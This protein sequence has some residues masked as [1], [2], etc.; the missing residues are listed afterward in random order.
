MHSP[1]FMPIVYLCILLSAFFLK[2]AGIFGPEDYKVLARI[3][4]NLTLPAAVIRA[5]S[6]FQMEWSL[7]LFVLLGLMM[8]ILPI[9]LALLLFPESSALDRGQAVLCSAGYCIG[10]FAFPFID[11]SIGA[12]GMV[13]ACLFDTGNSLMLT[14]VNYAVA[15]SVAEGKR[16]GFTD[17]MR[18]LFSSVPFCVY[19]AMLLMSILH[20][21]LP[22]ILVS[23]ITPL[24]N[25][26]GPIAML[27]LG[28]TLDFSCPKAEYRQVAGI[29]L[30]R[31]GLA[32]AFSLAVFF[33]LP[34]RTCYKSALILCSFCPV[35][36]M[37]TPFTEKLRGNIQRTGLASSISVLM[38]I[39]IIV[40][41]FS[42]LPLS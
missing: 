23:A 26:N 10:N 19:L 4:V 7:L 3:I 13:A 2:K 20:I 8:N 35:S 29:L 18:K 12:L 14:G 38:S 21:A 15:S 41:L 33:L 17:A 25:A 34:L 36:T 37:A 42:V 16:P 1:V 22:E 24:A 30:L 5:F 40:L 11:Y 31:Y 27:M 32:V 39:L 9:L 28:L 6:A